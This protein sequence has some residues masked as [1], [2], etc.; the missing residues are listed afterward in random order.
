MSDL[1]ELPRVAVNG[2]EI[3]AQAIAAEAQNHPAPDAA[4]AWQAAAEALVVRRLL[5]DE[6]ERLEIAPGE[7]QDQ[8]G[9]VLDQDEARIEALLAAEVRT[10][11]ADEATA[12]R[13]YEIHRDRFVSAPLVEAEHILFAAKPDDSLAYGLATGD[14]RTTI[15]QLQRDPSAFADLA[16]RHSACPSKEQGGNLGQIGAGQTV[17]EFEGALFSLGEGELHAEPVKTRFGVHVI[18]AGRRQEARELPFEL[19][20]DR[21]GQ[22]LEEAS[23]RRAVS[24]YLSVLAAQAKIEGVSLAAAESPLVQ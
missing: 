5:L 19:V 1:G 2:Q 24:Q 16:R 21:I 18:R 14:A 11:E 7:I 17:P 4:Q 10:P 8:E 15:R 3:P 9:R 20:R 13:Y 12:R 22:Y 6:A 23:W